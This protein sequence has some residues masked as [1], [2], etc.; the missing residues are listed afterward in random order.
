M[1]ES[2]AE[3][4][5]WAAAMA[6]SSSSSLLT[7]SKGFVVLALLLL[8]PVFLSPNSVLVLVFGAQAF[9]AGGAA[10]LGLLAAAAGAVGVKVDLEGPRRPN[11]RAIVQGSLLFVLGVV[12]IYAGFIGVITHMGA[13]Y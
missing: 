12:L 11:T 1:A 4:E 8:A 10:V 5:A 7:V 2:E 13:H 6:S 3:R 9:A